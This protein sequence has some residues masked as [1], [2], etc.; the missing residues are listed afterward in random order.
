LGRRSEVLL[1]QSEFFQ[2]GF[3]NAREIHQFP[4]LLPVC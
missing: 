4:N 1:L 2:A 3:N